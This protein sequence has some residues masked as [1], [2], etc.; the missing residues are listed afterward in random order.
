MAASRLLMLIPSSSRFAALLFCVACVLTSR[1]ASAATFAPTKAEFDAHA[2]SHQHDSPLAAERPAQVDESGRVYYAIDDMRYPAETVGIDSAFTAGTW[3]GGV[4]YYQFDSGVTATRR[5]QW[6]DAA[7]VWAAV[8]PLSFV[9]STG[10]GN[11]VRVKSSTST[12]S[13]YVGMV[14][15]AQE[16][17]IANWTYQFII[18]H[19]IGHALGLIHEQCRTDRGNYVTIL[20]QN[21]ASGQSHNFE[22]DYG[23]V[24]YGTYDFDSV[25]HYSRNEFS[26]SG[27]NTIEPKPQYASYLYTMGQT[28]HISGLDAS[29][30]AQRYGGSAQPI[31][32]DNFVARQSL[33]G[34]TGSVSA[35][36]VGATKEPSEPNHAGF[37]GGASI[38]YSW[39]APASGSVTIDTLESNFDTMLHVYQGNG[40]TGLTSI[41]GNDDI[42]YPEVRQSRVTF[43]AAAGQTYQIAVDG[44]GGASG[45][46]RLNWQAPAG[47]GL[48]S[49]AKADFDSD[50]HGDFIWQNMQT[51]ERVIWFLRNGQYQS[52]LGLP[53]IGSEWGIA[54]AAD[55]NADG[56]ADLVWQN[57]QTGDRAIWFLRNGQYQSGLSLQRVSGEWQIAGAADCNADGHADLVWQNMQTG[58]RAIWFL[59]DGQLQSAVL[60]SSVG[61]DWQIAGAGD[62]NN[63]GHADLAW[64]N[65]NSG[66]RAVWFLR[67]G[68]YQSGVS[69]PTVSAEWRIAAA[70]D[71]NAD[72]HADLAWQNVN[73]GARAIW[74][75]RNAVHQ[76][77]VYLSTVDRSWEISGH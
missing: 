18:A 53:V 60:L 61:V 49:S 50:G 31:P 35:N 72:G 3:P 13:S 39:T 62:F 4:L 52:Y 14:G 54:S 51:G 30:M 46:V 8:A 24:P 5:Q 36:S 74:F 66:A 10:V 76:S 28:T 44:Y 68:Q 1:G 43:S 7:A 57:S 63:D 65:I 47:S 73:S 22:I 37:P 33:S 70:A 34:A 42:A 71:Y 26:S 75:L 64:Q 41:A 29:G 23:S 32:N 19:E 9:E 45:A 77:D 48:G 16:M 27:S 40:V 59:R 38:W 21:I 20:T 2:A 67:D 69:L 15:G 11:F 58:Q 55:F 25:M 56:H 17:L 6:R 12:N